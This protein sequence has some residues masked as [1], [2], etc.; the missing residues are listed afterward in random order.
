[1]YTK[2]SPLDLR[3][4]VVGHFQD[5]DHSYAQKTPAIPN[6]SFFQGLMT[7]H[8]DNLVTDQVIAAAGSRGWGQNHCLVSIIL[9]KL[10]PH[11][12][13]ILQR[14]QWRWR[15]CNSNRLW[16][17]WR[18]CRSTS[19]QT[20]GF[21][22]ATSLW[23]P[24]LTFH[25]TTGASNWVR[26]RSCWTPCPC[27]VLRQRGCEI[28]LPTLP[29]NLK[30]DFFK[31]IRYDDVFDWDWLLPPASTRV[32]RHTPSYTVTAQFFFGGKSFQ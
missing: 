23:G 30:G 21:F 4:R 22:R 18:C 3:K 29:Q 14:A 8:Y 27:P 31:K 7:P 1:M 11:H 20:Q 5:Q 25:S 26:G 12:L 28:L 32:H 24:G 16:S 10:N 9:L 19:V 6:Y 17:G 15:I 13:Q 2:F